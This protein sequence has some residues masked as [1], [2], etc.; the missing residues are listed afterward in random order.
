MA[1]KKAIL[2]IC[3]KDCACGSFPAAETFKEKGAVFTAYTPG[4]IVA[5][6]QAV[7]GVV[8]A[9]ASEVEALLE[10]GTPLTVVDFSADAAGF[11]EGLSKIL[12]AAGRRV[13][14][15]MVCCKGLAFSGNGIAKAGQISRPATFKDVIPTL[16]YIAEIFIPAGLSGSVLYQA[17]KDSNAR[18]K[19]LGKMAE[20]LKAM[21]AAMERNS[22]QP[23]DKHDC[24]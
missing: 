3:P 8:F 14:I 1:E 6:A 2:V 18:L 20:S 4:D 15:C 10:A 17:L 11:N 19:E 23:W 24:A 12:E 21:E 22:R 13:T 16:G 7:E 5:E 9:K